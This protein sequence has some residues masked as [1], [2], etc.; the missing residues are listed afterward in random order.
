MYRSI[1]RNPMCRSAEPQIIQFCASQ[2]ILKIHILRQIDHRYDRMESLGMKA[3]K[4]K[5]ISMDLAASVMKKAKIVIKMEAGAK[6][7]HYK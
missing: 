5:S 4:G 3:Y 6:L 1:P 7:C 2:M